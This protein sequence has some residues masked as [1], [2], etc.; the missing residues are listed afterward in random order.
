MT[1]IAHLDG[2][3]DERAQVDAAETTH[4]FAEHGAEH[5]PEPPQPIDDLG[6]IGAVP[7]D[8]AEAFVQC[9]VG[10]V[11][12]GPILHDEDGHR[13]GGH[14]G[15]RPDRGVVMAGIEVGGAPCRPLFRLLPRGGKVLV[16]ERAGDGAAQRAAHPLP[17]DRRSGVED[18]VLRHPGDDF[19]RGANV[20]Q[21]WLSSEESLEGDAI[22]GVHGVTPE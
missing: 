22:G 4:R 21:H 2:L 6:S 12:R 1:L 9:R 20:H 11:A 17:R 10:A 3:P 16:H 8:L 13:R 14:T 15:H 7:K 19:D 18:R 5:V